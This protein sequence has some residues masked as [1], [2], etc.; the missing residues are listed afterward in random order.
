MGVGTSAAS[1]PKQ[2]G[3]VGGLITVGFTEFNTAG[4]I[5]TDE[6]DDLGDATFIRTNAVAG[7]RFATLIWTIR[8]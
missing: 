3:D 5:S 6:S 8:P 4:T 7:D 1:W 2:I